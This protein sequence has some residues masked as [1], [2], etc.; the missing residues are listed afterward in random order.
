MRENNN[1]LSKATKIAKPIKPTGSTRPTFSDGMSQGVPWMIVSKL[2]LFFVYL[3]VSVTTVRYLGSELYGEFA[4]CKGLAETLILICGLGL[5]TAFSRYVPELILNENKEGLIRLIVKSLVI[6]GVAVGLC[7]IVLLVCHGWLEKHFDIRFGFSILALCGLI[8][9]ELLKKNVNALLTACYQVRTLCT[10]AICHGVLWLVLLLVMMQLEASVLS[11]LLAPTVSFAMLYVLAMVIILRRV[12]RQAW[13]PTTHGVGGTRILRHSGAIAITTLLRL[14]MLK[15]TEL[16]FIG[17]TENADA[18]GLYELAYSI[19]MM[20]IVFIPSAT[21][22]LFAAGIAEAYVKCNKSLPILIRAYYKGLIL[23]AVPVAIFGFLTIKNIFVMFYGQA[24]TEA[25]ELASI[26]CLFHMLP[27]VSVPLSLGIQVKEKIHSM[28]PTLLF[29]LGVNIMLDYLLIVQL[30]L[31]IWGALIAVLATFALTIPVRL[32]RVRQLL[33]G[34]YF[35]VWFCV[36]VLI[37]CSATAFFVVGLIDPVDIY[38][39]LVCGVIYLFLLIVSF[40]CGGWVSA[41]DKTDLYK[42]ISKHQFER[43]RLMREQCLGAIRRV[44]FVVFWRSRLDG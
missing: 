22:D 33:G 44:T 29:Q 32:Y 24:F 5:P 30:G 3:M 12:R 15:Y 14:M 13:Q 40:V 41:E 10:F 26:F 37:V 38:R 23:Y 11:A 8:L 27:L 35:P 6:Q 21:Q 25:G 18:V 16:F 19:P 20:V 31:G 36:K 1:N 7:S 28:L 17:L 43:M 4:L 9:F 42:L 39:L 2:L 34:I